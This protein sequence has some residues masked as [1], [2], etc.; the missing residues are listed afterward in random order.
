MRCAKCG[1]D[2]PAGKKFCGDCGAPL[3]NSYPKCGGESPPGKRFCG[4]CGTALAPRN[5]TSQSPADSSST[6]NITISAE[7]MASAVAEGERK[8]V[9]ALFADI[10]GS[11]EL[12]EDLD[13]EEARAII[14]PAISRPWS[15]CRNVL[16]QFSLVQFQAVQFG[17]GPA[18]LLRYAS[19]L[20]QDSLA[21]CSCPSAFKKLLAY[22]NTQIC[23]IPWITR[24]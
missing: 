3:T 5:A 19:D 8:T 21:A 1:N 7:Q 15:S 14:D 12:M 10:K 18:S 2:N 9:S 23:L 16:A 4:D 13:P 24:R 11:M 6:P 17:L 20:V 22:K